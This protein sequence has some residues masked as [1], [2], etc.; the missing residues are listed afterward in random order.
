MWG[1]RQIRIATVQ[2]FK[3]GFRPLVAPTFGGQKSQMIGGH[4]GG[5]KSQIRSQMISQLGQEIL[6]F[7]K[8][9]K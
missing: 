9:F 4:I 2:D 8:F 1:V 7:R 6:I 3:T 5:Q